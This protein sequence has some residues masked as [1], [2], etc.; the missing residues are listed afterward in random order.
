MSEEEQSGDSNK[1]SEAAKWLLDFAKRL[2]PMFVTHLAA[3]SLA[4]AVAWYGLKLGIDRYL[5]E[6]DLRLAD[7]QAAAKEYRADTK[8]QF[9][10]VLAEV[11]RGADASAVIARDVTDVR[12]RIATLEAQGTAITQALTA[13]DTP[14]PTQLFIPVIDNQE[15]E[16]IGGP[17][18]GLVTAPGFI[19]MV[20]RIDPPRNLEERNTAIELLRERHR[21]SLLAQSTPEFI[22]GVHN[23]VLSYTEIML[24][25]GTIK[26]QIRSK[27]V[28]EGSE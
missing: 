22:E 24:P 14:T 21:S 13:V 16:F 8:D 9:T 27:V 23:F 5:D 3:F 19:D 15:E 25:D 18:I 26:L 4:A 12:V 1:G 17:D 11:K 20:S 7:L 2:L 6:R 28:V 10:A